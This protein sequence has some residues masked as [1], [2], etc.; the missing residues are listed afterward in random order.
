MER[1]RE[2]YLV[3]VLNV[4]NVVIVFAISCPGGYG[5]GGGS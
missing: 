4:F 3:A 1:I 5:K 2:N